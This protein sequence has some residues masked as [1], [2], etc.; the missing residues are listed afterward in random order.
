M[1][2]L[3]NNNFKLQRKTK[4]LIASISESESLRQAMENFLDFISTIGV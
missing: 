3:W 4:E 1:L 2:M